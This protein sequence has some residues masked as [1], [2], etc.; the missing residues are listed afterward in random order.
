MVFRAGYRDPCT[1]DVARLS[2][3]V[4]I[5]LPAARVLSRFPKISQHPACMDRAILHGKPFSNPLC[6]NPK[7]QCRY[8]VSK[9]SLLL[10]LN[11]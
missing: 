7:S 4:K 11:S 2:E 9:F 3:S 8:S 5:H 1:W 6:W 10:L